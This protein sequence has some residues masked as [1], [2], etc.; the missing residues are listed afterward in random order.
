MPSPSRAPRPRPLAEAWLAT[1]GW[2][3][4]PFQRQ[5]WQ[6]IAQGRSGLLH[7][8][9]G[10]GKTYAVWLGA[11]QAFGTEGQPT[12]R[13]K[14]RQSDGIASAESRG[15]DTD[16]TTTGSLSPAE[17]PA[18]GKRAHA[19]AKAPPSEPLT[20]LWLTPM[21][22]LAAD[23]LKALR[24][25]LDE[26]AATH[27]VLARW[28]S[29]AR[30]GDTGSAE[31]GAQSRRLPTVL[32]TTPESLSL[33][34][35]RADAQELLSSL[36]LVVAD[37]WHEL[38]GNK[39][40][41]QVQLALARLA[42]WNPSLRVW[43]MS[44]TLGNLPEAQEALLAPLGTQALAEGVQVQGQVDK[45][46]V[47]DT[48]LP[49]HPERFSWAGHLGLRMLPAVV[50]E[51][52]STS[53]TLVFVNV[54]SQAELWYKAILDA[55]PDW[56]G[57]LA[58]HHGSLD[59][60]VREWVEAGL[61]EGRLRAVV[62]TSS[63][64]LGVDFLPVE[65]V[66]QI[67]SA[68]GIA[69]LLQ[70]AGRSGHAPGRPS[71][72]T[73]VPTHSLEL[74]EAAAARAAVQAGEVE[75]R[76]SPRRPVDVLVQHLVTVAL[77]GGFEPEALYAEV[78]RTVAY[79]DL[80][81]A[82]WQ[83]CLDFV[84]RGGPSLAAY[85]DYQRVAPDDEGIWRMPSA[86]LARRHRSNIGTIVSDASM[87]VQVLHGARLGT[88]EES[89]LSRLSP[90]DCFVFAGQVL[91]MVK[92]E[93]MTAYVR[94]AARGRPTVP[95]WAGS[96]MP[97]STVLADFVVQQLALAAAGRYGSP[98]LRCVRPLLDV[99]QRWSALPTPG[100]LLAETLRTREGWH[101]F[102]YPF[103]GR[104]AHTGLASL[105]AWRAAQGEA[106]T[107][108]IAVND[109]GLE[110]LSATER[111]WAALLPELL[112]VR[113]VATQPDGDAHAG[114]ASGE[115]GATQA[116]G[117]MDAPDVPDG[118]IAAREALAIRNTANAARAEAED[119]AGN[120]AEID[121]DD[122]GDDTPG[123]RG[124]A[125]PDAERHALLHEV[126]ASLNAT[127]MARRRFREIARVSGLIFQSHPGERRSARQLQASSQLFFEVFRK[128]DTG[129]MLLRQADEEV[130]SQELDV[131]QLLAALRRMQAQELVVK[132]LTRPSPFAFPLMI[133]RFREKLTNE[134]LAD[135]IA[136]MLAQLDT[137]ADAGSAAPPESVAAQEVVP[138]DP[139]ARPQRRRAAAK[140]AAAADADADAGAQTPAAPVSPAQTA[141]QE[142]AD[143]VRRTLDFS[144]TS[145][146]ESGSGGAPG[147]A[148]AR[149][150]ERKPSRPLPRL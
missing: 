139:P 112:R 9:T 91:E 77:G 43:G 113:A 10:A 36:R 6:A 138:P 115:A 93:D 141:M 128:Y 3:P 37:E 110:L 124:A 136:R 145:T 140:K 70:R 59:R 103:A 97:L 76:A 102:V 66:L 72:I 57:E 58:I 78:R 148:R 62:C 111:D 143:A 48:L 29:G 19:R 74:V 75:M 40:G 131:A 46:L 80:P 133:E 60:G 12:T 84:H 150:R 105:F 64:D 107:F 31:R 129:N 73:L 119:A 27:P 61:K 117:G 20:V 63:L 30:T 28:T 147:A 149:R 122:G 65:R 56:A 87:A 86:R 106:G 104:H 127:E 81:R 130:L 49:D 8:T 118:R 21:R 51:L 38:L 2:R 68:K 71:R 55:R 95:R 24:T 11:L 41:V 15:A 135:R 4:F 126:L 35:A 45:K 25:P 134:D 67:G 22:A 33:L 42:G 16:T 17:D 39:R 34:L 142:A 47:V 50:R 123:S 88:M 54:R 82:V 94:R 96:R 69:R 14:K 18:N 108:S 32:V 132:P 90:G 144:L 125:D 13:T 1:R 79:R 146:E 137:A 114:D 26:L 53:T 121:G 100:T 89:F 98:E 44:A 92:I 120:G 83:W 109:Y 7:A 116:P 85:P 5:V 101:L 52:E 23:T 99:Q